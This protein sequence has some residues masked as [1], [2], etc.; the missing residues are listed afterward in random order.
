MFK[1]LCWSL[2]AASHARSTAVHLLA[3]QWFGALG[4][5]R[6]RLKHHTPHV[7]VELNLCWGEMRWIWWPHISCKC[8]RHIDATSVCLEL[9]LQPLPRLVPLLGDP[10]SHLSSL[11]LVYHV[12]VWNLPLPSCF[13]FGVHTSSILTSWPSHC[14]RLSRSTFSTVTCS[15]LLTSL[16]VT[17]S[18]VVIPGCFSISTTDDELSNQSL[19]TIMSFVFTLMCLSVSWISHWTVT[20]NFLQFLKSLADSSKILRLSLQNAN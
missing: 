11:S 6:K 7:M 1:L 16:F 12:F 5:V 17:L 19:I 4:K 13:V 14:V 8:Y 2:P 15:V 3:V 10:S 9:K 18:L 20:M